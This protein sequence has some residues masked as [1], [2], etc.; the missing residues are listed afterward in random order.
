MWTTVFE[1]IEG[2]LYLEENGVLR[3]K[4][5]KAKYLVKIESVICHTKVL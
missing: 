1:K 3:I 4:F 2:K 5:I